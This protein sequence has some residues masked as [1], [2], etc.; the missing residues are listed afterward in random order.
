MGVYEF[1][2][3][4]EKERQN[5]HDHTIHKINLLNCFFRLKPYYQYNVLG[6]NV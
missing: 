3:Q 5:I 4:N 1:K 6:T 2:N